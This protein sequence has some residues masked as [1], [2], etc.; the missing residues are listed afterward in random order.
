MQSHKLENKEKKGLI[1]E[2][3]INRSFESLMYI[4][5]NIGEDKKIDFIKN[6]GSYFNITFFDIDNTHL[7][8]I[9]KT[10][11]ENRIRIIQESYGHK[12]RGRSILLS[13]CLYAGRKLSKVSFTRSM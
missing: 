5:E 2:L 4:Y 1:F 8:Y 11:K 12:K 10:K 7:R 3:L 13:I 9:V 6:A